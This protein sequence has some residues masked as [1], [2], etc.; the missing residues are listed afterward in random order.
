[1]EKRNVDFET[2]SFLPSILICYK[3]R[4]RTNPKNIYPLN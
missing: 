1:M 3:G 2:G 4:K